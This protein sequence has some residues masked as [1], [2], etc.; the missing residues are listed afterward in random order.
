[1]HLKAIEKLSAKASGSHIGVQLNAQY[2]AEQKLH[3][4]MLLKLLEAVRFLGRQGLPLTGHFE[5]V[6]SF[7]GNSYKLYLL[8]QSKD[9]PGMRQW[10]Q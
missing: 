7:G 4:T 3:K 1:M 5:D 8:L 9:C 6:E 10:L 2:A